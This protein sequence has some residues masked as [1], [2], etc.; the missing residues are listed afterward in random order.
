MPRFSTSA[1][2]AVFVAAAAVAALA[3]TPSGAFAQST[4]SN[5]TLSST[6]VPS[7]PPTTTV[8]ASTTAAPAPTYPA[9]TAFLEIRDNFHADQFI[10]RVSDWLL[11]HFNPNDITI[12]PTT[13]P[14]ANVRAMTFS[15]ASAA[16]GYEQALK[17][18]T[19]LT[20]AEQ[21]ELGVYAITAT[22][23]Q[24]T[25]APSAGDNNGGDDKFVII[26]VS[27]GSV[28]VIALL[29][30][31]GYIWRRTSQGNSE[32]QSLLN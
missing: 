9:Y 25:N 4:T 2:F 24:S 21:V 18:G 17:I 1:L 29:V 31:L 30:A 27:V 13:P 11:N 26:V 14:I 8:T 28:F 22:I 6:A 23:Q 3:L 12:T 20:A 32:S 7:P 19:N 15:G 16:M 5:T 10:A